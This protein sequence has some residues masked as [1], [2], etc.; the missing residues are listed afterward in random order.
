MR[1]MRKM[2]KW[3]IKEKYL[4]HYV[5]GYHS[6]SLQSGFQYIYDQCYELITTKSCK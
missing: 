4:H 6:H 3:V 2:Y 5:T 1:K